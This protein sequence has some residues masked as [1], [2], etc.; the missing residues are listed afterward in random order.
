MWWKG[1]GNDA[2]K[3]DHGSEVR[4][5]VDM[6]LYIPPSPKRRASVWPVVAIGLGLFIVGGSAAI[7]IGMWTTRDERSNIAELTAQM[8]AAEVTRAARVDTMVLPDA[9]DAAV[10]AMVAPQL[11]IDEE[12]R[13]LTDRIAGG[14]YSVAVVRGADRRPNLRLDLPGEGETLERLAEQLPAAVQD[15]RIIQPPGLSMADGGLDVQ[16]FV[17]HLVQAR[18]QEGDAQSRDVAH[19]LRRQAIASLGSGTIATPD[20]Y[21][22]TLSEGDTLALIALVFYGDLNAHSRIVAANPN[23]LSGGNAPVAG[24]RLRIPGA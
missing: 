1:I 4:G 22:H 16:S 21:L 24:Q 3:S 9:A 19:S 15:G 7:G 14:R 5:P 18:L 2:G 17:Y 23:I 6:S 20:G 11:S 8:H 13:A 10:Q 12:L